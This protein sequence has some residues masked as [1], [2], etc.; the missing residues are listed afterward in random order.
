[1]YILR[2]NLLNIFLRIFNSKAVVFYEY[3]PTPPPPKKKK[4]EP[5][6]KGQKKKAFIQS[7]L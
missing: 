2:Y 7:F 6:R 3:P 5:R 1:M 4:I